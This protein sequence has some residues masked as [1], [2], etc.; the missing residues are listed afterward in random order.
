MTK[1]TANIKDR[2]FL[3]HHSFEVRFGYRVGS[4]F[5]ACEHC[6]EKTTVKVGKRD[7][8]VYLS[9]YDVFRTY[10]PSRQGFMYW[11]YTCG[12][13]DLQCWKRS[14]TNIAYEV[15]LASHSVREGVS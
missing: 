4:Y 12:A 6:A 14:E 10:Q 3:T 11:C 1:R 8:T 7:I 15:W 9:G 5:K 2:K 13:K